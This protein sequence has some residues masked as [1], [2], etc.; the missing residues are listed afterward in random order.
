MGLYFKRKIK[1]AKPL[2]LMQSHTFRIS[3]NKKKGKKKNPRNR[4]STRIR[5]RA[6]GS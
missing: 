2:D 4:L 1:P 6:S 5:R 3:K